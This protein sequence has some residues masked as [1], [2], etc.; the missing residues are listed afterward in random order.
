MVA[1]R[2][3]IRGGHRLKLVFDLGQADLIVMVSGR[4]AKDTI[5]VFDSR[6]RKKCLWQLSGRNGLQG[7][8]APLARAFESVFEKATLQEARTS[9]SGH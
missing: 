4:P 6:N 5:K 3:V 2:R 8:D 9:E 1:T 7:Q